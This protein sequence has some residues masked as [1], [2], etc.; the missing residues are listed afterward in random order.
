MISQ[1]LSRVNFIQL[2]HRLPTP[3]LSDN[4]MPAYYMIKTY[5]Q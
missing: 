4:G 3:R 1:K 2:N 5:F